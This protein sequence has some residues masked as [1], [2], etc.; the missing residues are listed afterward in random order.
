MGE[1]RGGGGTLKSS[2]G[3]L[4]RFQSRKDET[5]IQK[6]W[7]LS[8][9]TLT[10]CRSDWTSCSPR[11]ISSLVNPTVRPKVVVFM[12][13]ALGYD[14]AGHEL[15]QVLSDHIGSL[16]HEAWHYGPPNG[17][18]AVDY[19]P[20]CVSAALSVERGDTGFAVVLGGSGQGEQM[21]ANKVR[22]IRAALCTNREYA[23]MARRDNDA[24]VIA[25]P[26]RLI[27]PQYA[28]QILDE[29]M[30]TPFEGGRHARRIRFLHDYENNVYNA[31][32]ISQTPSRTDGTS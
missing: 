10:G 9:P 6:R 30:A 12:K 32:M 11:M 7:R 18:E 15:A 17:D 26:A 20:H 3:D 25:M 8:N 23:H 1:L 19:G 13:I 22:G 28:I 16:G 2:A 21:A 24:N 5:L 31:D 4:C 14:H 27:S 29:W